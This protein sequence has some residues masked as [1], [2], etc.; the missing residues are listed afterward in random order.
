MNTKKEIKTKYL[1]FI[2]T[3]KT[4]LDNIEITETK[5]ES[6]NLIVQN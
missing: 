6:S 1:A 5:S 3:P 2:K 4:R